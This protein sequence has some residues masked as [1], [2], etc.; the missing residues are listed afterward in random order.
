MSIGKRSSSQFHLS[1]VSFYV[2]C[3][4][5]NGTEFTG[6]VFPIYTLHPAF[7]TIVS[8]PLQSTIFVNYFRP[9]SLSKKRWAAF[10]LSFSSSGTESLYLAWQTT[11]SGFM[12][13][14][15]M[16]RVSGTESLSFFV[17]CRKACNKQKTMATE[18]SGQRWEL[19]STCASFILLV[20]SF[21]K[22]NHIMK[23]VKSPEED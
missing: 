1:Y 22:I 4:L 17:Y 9:T 8:L 20:S 2:L 11:S 18:R 7:D 12:P 21:F 6:C 5:Y 16:L 3:D 14:N 19:Q 13:V 23:A 15:S 10:L